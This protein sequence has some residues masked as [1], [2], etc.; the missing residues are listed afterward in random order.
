MVWWMHGWQHKPAQAK[1]A[2]FWNW[3]ND[4]ASMHDF[5]VGSLYWLPSVFFCCAA[6]HLHDSSHSM[7]IT[8]FNDVSLWSSSWF[9]LVGI[10]RSKVICSSL[11]MVVYPAFCVVSICCCCCRLL[12]FRFRAQKWSILR[13]VASG[14]SQGARLWTESEI[15]AWPSCWKE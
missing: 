14:I 1:A 11:F 3:S 6:Q 8:Y 12:R 2:H 4:A 15:I 9:A 10:T 13:D 5:D 7:S